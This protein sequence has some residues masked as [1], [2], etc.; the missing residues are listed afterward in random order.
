MNIF[1][2]PNKCGFCEAKVNKD[3]CAILQYE[4]SDSDELQEKFMCEECTNIILGES[5]DDDSIRFF[6]RNP[7]YK[8]RSLKDK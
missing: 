6:E 2:N 4:V 7:N 5:V 3:T 8:R 1:R